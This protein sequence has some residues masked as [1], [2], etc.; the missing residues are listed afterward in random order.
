MEIK[1]A[2]EG[3]AKWRAL[4]KR[5]HSL[6]KDYVTVYQEIQKY[7]F[8]VGPV[9][10]TEDFEVLTQIIEL[11]EGGVQQGKRVLEITSTDVAAFADGMI[12]GTPTLADSVQ[13]QV[14]E[15]VAK[16]VQK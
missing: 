3:K 7:Y 13:K 5:A 12:A 6:P 10:L 4:Q 14:D 2:F 16:A 8:K 1:K 11:F 9:G 15:S